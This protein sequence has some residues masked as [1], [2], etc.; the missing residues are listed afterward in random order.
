MIC[1]K[2][3]TFC[4]FYQNC[5]EGKTCDRALTPEVIDQ[6]VKWWRGKGAPI[7]QYAEKP[8][9]WKSS[10][11]AGSMSYGGGPFNGLKE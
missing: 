6:A 8:K 7:A 5:K 1:Y 10:E 4:P 9:C 3:K 2:D 11:P